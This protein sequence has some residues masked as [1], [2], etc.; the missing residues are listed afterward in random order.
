MPRPGLTGPEINVLKL[1]GPGFASP[2]VAGSR[3]AGPGW[4]GLA[5]EP[6]SLVQYLL[7]QVEFK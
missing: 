2:K 5:I 3:L 6:E 4:A 1:T 7:V